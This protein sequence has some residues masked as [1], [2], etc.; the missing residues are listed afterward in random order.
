MYRKSAA[1]V[2]AAML[3]AGAAG[4]QVST[5]AT[6]R[7]GSPVISSPVGPPDE[8]PL[9]E[10]QTLVPRD[11]PLPAMLSLEQALDE[12]EA[13][14]PTIIAAQARVEAAEARIR[15]AG[16]RVNPDLS[17]EIE[18]F[19]G[20]G[21][22]S[23]LRQT[24][25]TVS[26]NQRLDLGGRRRARIAVAGATL[27]SERLRL[28]IARA[29]LAQSVR[30]QFARAVSARERLRI[31]QENEAN[32]REVARVAGVLVAEGRDPPLRAVRARSAA[33][34]A[35]A[36]LEAARAEEVSARGTLASLF[37]VVEPPAGVVGELLAPPPQS[38]DPRLSLEIRLAEAERA[39]AESEVTAQLA[40]GRLD[41]AVGLGVR[42]VRETGDFA[43]VG[44]ISLPLQVF[45]R[46]QGNIAAAR[47]EVRSA[48]ATLANASASVAARARNA[49]I[50]VEAAEARVEA[51]EGAGVPEAAEALRLAQ[52]SY[53]EGRAS[54]LELLDAQNASRTAQLALVDAR[55]SLANA[56]A[57]LGRVAAQ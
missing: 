47:A 43:L 46:N 10:T 52:L 30:Q 11:G 16:Y 26:L 24:E 8:A 22:L 20:T 23:G 28:A 31:A 3:V 36:E 53:R 41:P 57:E 51:L 49:A 33:A 44:G 48:E 4:A 40:Q 17:I 5:P 35:S 18:N 29:D 54:L 27:A 42:H 39:R 25:A 12:A 34:Q 50:A 13:R 14:S 7:V 6:P 1:A 32:A 37:G 15:Q 9:T 2:A 56:I 38:V 19:L 55:L 45:D 21:E